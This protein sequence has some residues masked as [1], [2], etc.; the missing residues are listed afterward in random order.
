MLLFT[1][2]SGLPMWPL[3]ILMLALLSLVLRVCDHYLFMSLPPIGTEA[4]AFAQREERLRLL[5]FMAMEHPHHHG[6]NDEY[7][8]LLHE[9]Q[10]GTLQGQGLPQQ[11][12]Q[13]QQQRA[14]QPQPPPPQPPSETDIKAL[15]T[16]FTSS[17]Y[18]RNISI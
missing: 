14:L 18:Y 7:S 15:L 3:F 2:F 9:I 13:Q 8:Q 16:S 6:G 11:Q 10:H 4:Y 12:Q 1:F 5:D 17:R